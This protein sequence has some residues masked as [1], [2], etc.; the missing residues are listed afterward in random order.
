MNRFKICHRKLIVIVLALVVMYGPAKAQYQEELSTVVVQVNAGSVL[1]SNMGN[2]FAYGMTAQVLIP[3]NADNYFTAG[4]KGMTNPFDGDS[5]F[6]LKN[7]FNRS[8]DALNYLMTFTGLR[9]SLGRP[10]SGYFFTEPK[11]GVAF[12]H[13]FAWSG[14]CLTPSI[15]Y[16]IENLEFQAFIDAGFDETKLNI[17]KKQFFTAGVGIGYQIIQI[18]RKSFPKYFVRL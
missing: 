2:R 9:V 5:F 10:A 12:A 18:K 6:F 3:I 15:G 1:N 8:G 17:R 7:G 13:G 4:I 16:K 14:I 11:A